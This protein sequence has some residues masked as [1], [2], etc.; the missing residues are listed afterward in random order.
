MAFPLLHNYIS[1]NIS[2]IHGFS[3]F[4]S[5]SF[6]QILMILFKCCSYDIWRPFL[7]LSPGEV[8][9]M[10]ASKA[11]KVCAVDFTK[12]KVNFVV[13][14]KIYQILE[15]D[16]DHEYKCIHSQSVDR[17]PESIPSILIPSNP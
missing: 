6:L 13:Q 8:K 7:Q 10:V 5:N 14:N 17:Y 15:D 16:N 9:V 2:G 4:H 1:I 11:K 12:R 3:E